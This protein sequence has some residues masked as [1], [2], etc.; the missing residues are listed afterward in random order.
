MQKHQELPT[1]FAALGLET[2]LLKSLAAVGFEKPTEIQEK[3]IP[4]VLGGRDVMGM[5]RTGTGKTAAFGLPIL[6]LL[7]TH[8]PLG[9]L[10]LVPTRELAVQVAAELDRLGKHRKVR[11]IA[12]YG[13]QKVSVQ[14]HQLGDKPH[15]LV[16]TPGRVMDFLG[17]RAIHFNNIKFAVLDEVDRMLDIG[18]RDDIRKILS[19]VKTEHQTVLVSATLSDEVRRLAR[20]YMNNPLELNVSQDQM[21][22]E[23]V[24][25]TYVSVDPWDK[26]ACLKAILDREDIRLAI[27]F[28]NT[29]HGARKLARKLH[30]VGVE[31]N[32][33]HG[34][35][36]QR[37]RDRVMEGFRKHKIKVL[38]ATDLASRGID[39]QAISHIINYDL[40][41]D[42]EVYVH[43][44]GRTA[45]M[46][47]F[48]RAI[49][50]VGKDEGK[51]LTEVE[52]LIN[53][54]VPVEEVKGFTR[55]PPPREHLDDHPEEAVAAASMSRLQAPAF[56]DGSAAGGSTATEAPI[57]RTLG[58]KFRPARRRRR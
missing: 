14:L 15:I 7:D 5:A 32:E 40:P 35:L 48:G 41:K 31:A 21:T 33:I 39:V 51:Y 54:E 23:E 25:Q 2:P 53:K 8:T 52:M 26:F 3:V 10:I 28:T 13:G 37:K 12:V 9:A 27:V 20:Q 49:S 44:I 16:G 1:K 38:V 56:G 11:C 34:D 58:G 45:R 17:R 43:R 55:R 50:L 22:V 19:Q 6:Q 30:Q 4:P 42:P 47:N 24:R 46:G 36:L 18:F 57:K 29:K